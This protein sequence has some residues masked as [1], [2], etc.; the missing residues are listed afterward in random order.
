MTVTET[1]SMRRPVAVPGFGLGAHSPRRGWIST[2]CLLVL[3]LSLSACSTTQVF[4]VAGPCEPDGLP[5][6]RTVDL[7]AM[8]R[9]PTRLTGFLESA[10]G[11]S[12]RI[13]TTTSGVDSIHTFAC[14]KVSTITYT[15][16]DKAAMR[17]GARLAGIVASG[18]LAAFVA[19]KCLAPDG[20][21]DLFE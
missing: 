4:R 20:G 17:D 14:R 12:L 9:P 21:C 19:V 15:Y 2:R 1:D 13:V 7:V 8:G 18:V 16:R 5:V 11:D 3:G 6:R 10:D